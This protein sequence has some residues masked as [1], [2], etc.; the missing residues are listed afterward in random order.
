MQRVWKVW[1]IAV[2]WLAVAVCGGGPLAA[3]V[4][5]QSRLQLQSQLQSQSQPQSQ[6]QAPSSSPQPASSRDDM[7]VID[8][9]AHP[10]D[11]PDHW[12]WRATFHHV[13]LTKKMGKSKLLDQIGLTPPDMTLLL[14]TSA[15]QETR[16]LAC[17]KQIADRQTELT[18]QHANADALRQAFRDTTIEC[19]IH[20]LDARDYLL[21][22]LSPDGRDR[23]VQ[24]VM[25][26][27]SKMTAHVP[28]A[29]LDYFKRPQ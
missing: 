23:L 4:Q 18:A 17:E 20:D 12:V 2:V 15:A 26:S 25:D 6:R 11:L 29:D 14:D 10:E 21:Q 19:R 16:D 13:A 27:R 1:R 9:K 22:A 24:W 28:A 5:P 8:G 7:V 3:A